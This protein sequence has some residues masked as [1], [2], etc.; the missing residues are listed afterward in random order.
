MVVKEKN[1]YMKTIAGFTSE[2]YIV[3][4]DAEWC[5]NIFTTS[6][7]DIIFRFIG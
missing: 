3:I 4:Y 7:G 2:D 6:S 1:I 5:W